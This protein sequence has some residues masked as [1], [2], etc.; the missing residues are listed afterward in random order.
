MAQDQ[1][2]M[3]CTEC[4]RRNYNSSKN[5]KNVTERLE[6]RRYCK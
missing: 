6:L 3:A 1:V 5:K 2:T 4:Q